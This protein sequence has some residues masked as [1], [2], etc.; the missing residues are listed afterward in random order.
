M[1]KSTNPFSGLIKSVLSVFSRKKEE[2]LGKQRQESKEVSRP[3][4]KVKRQKPM[5]DK[6]KVE[7]EDKKPP[8]KPH[9]PQR[10]QPVNVQMPAPWSKVEKFKRIKKEGQHYDSY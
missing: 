3:K 2:N 10:P 6:A 8:K 1:V 9:N 5:Q 7:T 4:P